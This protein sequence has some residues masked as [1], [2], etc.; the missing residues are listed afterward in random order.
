VDGSFAPAISSADDE[1]WN[2]IM[3]EPYQARTKGTSRSSHCMEWF[4][5][6][7]ELDEDLGVAEASR[8]R[9]R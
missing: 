6:T 9:F 2:A 8:S 7:I 1:E 3:D 4:M 5:K